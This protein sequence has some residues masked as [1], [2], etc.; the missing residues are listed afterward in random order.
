MPVVA[1]SGYIVGF[2]V[3]TS[4]DNNTYGVLDLLQFGIGERQ[5]ELIPILVFDID[6]IEYLNA[7]YMD[8]EIRAISLVVNITSG[9][10]NESIWV[11]E[12]IVNF[13][14]CV[15]EDNRDGNSS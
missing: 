4:K 9:K 2:R 13:N 15:K 12:K 3:K 5:T 8:G 14:S 1:V 10:K 6:I 7:R 11:V